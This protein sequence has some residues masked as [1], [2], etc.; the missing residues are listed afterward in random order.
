VVVVS[1][2]SYAVAQRAVQQ[3]QRRLLALKKAK[4]GHKSTY[5][6]SESSAAAE[7]ERLSGA[8][9]QGGDRRRLAQHSAALPG[10]SSSGC[11][12]LMRAAAC[13]RCAPAAGCKSRQAIAT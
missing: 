8:L 13:E 9:Q 6:G 2:A 12:R 4:P 3:Q 1:A 7:A 11:R 5:I 10:R